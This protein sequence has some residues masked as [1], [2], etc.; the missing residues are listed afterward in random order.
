L[1]FMTPERLGETWPI[2]QRYPAIDSYVKD[3][4]GNAQ[5]FVHGAICKS[6][7]IDWP[8]SKHFGEEI[9]SWQLCMQTTCVKSTAKDVMVEPIKPVNVKGFRTRFP[10]AFKEYIAKHGEEDL[11]DHE[12]S[13]TAGKHDTLVGPYVPKKVKGA[14]IAEQKAELARQ[15]KLL[16]AAEANQG[17][18]E[19]E[20]P[21]LEDRYSLEGG[22]PIKDMR[23]IGMKAK[24]MLEGIG[25]VTIEGLANLSDYV[26]PD[27]G[28]GNWE[29]YRTLARQKVDEMARQKAEALAA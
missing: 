11:P 15:M 29:R 22:H 26:I 21:E 24:E 27:L 14:S 5:P 9:L 3:E 10:D 20:E 1:S 25:V 4:M 8:A 12:T 7:V 18:E 13:I 16:E 19:P 2:T 6:A 17:K 28:P 23:G